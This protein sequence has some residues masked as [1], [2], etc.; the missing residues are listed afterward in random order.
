MG[1]ASPSGRSSQTRFP[2]SAVRRRSVERILWDAH[3]Y[4]PIRRMRHA[5]AGSVLQASGCFCGYRLCCSSGGLN[6]RCPH[7]GTAEHRIRRKNTSVTSVKF[8]EAAWDC[9]KNILQGTT[10]VSA[11][12]SLNATPTFSSCEFTGLGASTWGFSSCTGR[13]P[14]TLT[15]GTENKGTVTFNCPFTIGASA[16]GCSVTLTEQA[17]LAEFNWMNVGTKEGVRIKF[18]VKKVKTTV[19]SMFCEELLKGTEAEFTGTYEIKN[20]YVS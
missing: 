7:L 4:S 20:I 2:S 9:N 16:L 5:K 17:N 8:T 11:S 3:L 13:I 12:A 6:G 10:A 14:W 18:A 19:S 1:R 15:L